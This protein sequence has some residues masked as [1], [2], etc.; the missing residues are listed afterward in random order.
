MEAI[1]KNRQT[2]EVLRAMVARAFG[3]AQVPD[4]QASDGQGWVE[5]LSDGY[6][7][8]AYQLRLRDGQRVVLKIAPSPEVEVMAYEQGMMANEV[9]ALTLIRERTGV[10]VPAVLF[11]DPSCELCDADYFFMDFVDG[12]NL[13][14]IGDTL[15]PR[16][17]QAYTE[18]VGAAN[19]ALNQIKGAH[20]GPLLGGDPGATWREVFTGL[21]ESVL[22]DGERRD[23]ALGVGYDAVREVMVRSA[24]SLDDVTEPVFVEWD[25]WNGNVLVRDGEIAGIIDHE[26]ALYG[27][28]LMENGFVATSMEGIGD[29]TGFVRGYGRTPTTPAEIT[30]RRLYTLYLLLIMTIETVYREFPDSEQYDWSRTWLLRLMEL[31]DRDR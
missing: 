7:N 23:V 4:G 24:G 9:R 2:T 5:E 19:L 17:Y 16:E 31:F 1:T 28:P 25:L 6:F 27:D 12:D 18:A 11:Y 29:P 8:V 22:R 14:T 10:P 30:R 20:F 15:P 26:R 13:A 21:V 3:D